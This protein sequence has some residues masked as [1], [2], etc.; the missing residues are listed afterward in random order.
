MNVTDLT[1]GGELIGAGMCHEIFREILVKTGKIK[2]YASVDSA[3]IA[4]S[5]SSARET[6][7]ERIIRKSR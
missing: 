1:E 4:R 5:V 2:G 3:W 6:E 7:E